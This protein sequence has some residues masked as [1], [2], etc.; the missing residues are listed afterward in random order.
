MNADLSVSFTPQSDPMDQL[1]RLNILEGSLPI[2]IFSDYDRNWIFPSPDEIPVPSR[3]HRPVVS[4]E[5]TL[6]ESKREERKRLLQSSRKCR[7]PP[8]KRVKFLNLDE[9][10]EKPIVP[11]EEPVKPKNGSLDLLVNVALT[12]ITSEGGTQVS[13]FDYFRA[14]V[15]YRLKH[16]NGKVPSSFHGHVGVGLGKWVY[17]QKRDLMRYLTEDHR[18]TEKKI[19]QMEMLQIAGFDKEWLIG[20]Y[21][22]EQGENGEG[23]SLCSTAPT[24]SRIL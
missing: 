8:K 9:K 6:S 5:W 14:L 20:M 10:V 22:V 15:E 16:G 24:R 19:A 12:N 3:S 7:V 13:W 18:M 17:R 21:P 23:E 4:D 11:K 2:P 1:H